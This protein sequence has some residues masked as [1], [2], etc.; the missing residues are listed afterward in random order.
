MKKIDKIDERIIQLKEEQELTDQEIADKLYY[1]LATIKKRLK[2]IEE[3]LGKKLPK[4]P[5]ESKLNKTDYEMIKLREKTLDEIAKQMGLRIETM[6]LKKKKI[7]KLTNIRFLE[8]EKKE[9]RS[10]EMDELD[11]VIINLVQ[12]GLTDRQVATQ[13][14]CSISIIRHRKYRMENKLR[15][16]I[17][18]R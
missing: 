14:N 15:N 3:L 10:I 11:N 1:S 16:C 5:K 12:Q 8:E 17:V 7:E 18:C 13:L 9:P 6:R 4:L 2:K